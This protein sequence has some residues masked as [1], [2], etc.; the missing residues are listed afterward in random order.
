MASY[1]K[2]T[3]PLPIPMQLNAAVSVVG[4]IGAT[5]VLVFPISFFII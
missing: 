2:D 5:L 3:R 4:N 1:F